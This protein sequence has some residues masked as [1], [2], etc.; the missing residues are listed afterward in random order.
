[1]YI[2]IAI[3]EQLNFQLKYNNLFKL[4]E[5]L[6]VMYSLLNTVKRIY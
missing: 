1:M 5:K 6:I 2:L 3:S 4:K